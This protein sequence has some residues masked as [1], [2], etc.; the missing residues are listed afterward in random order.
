[1]VDPVVRV[2]TLG[3]IQ[4]HLESNGYEI[5]GNAVFEA[6]MLIGV[7]QHSG[8]NG[9]EFFTFEEPKFRQQINRAIAVARAYDLPVIPSKRE[10]I[11]NNV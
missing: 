1:M 7:L 11:I 10:Y 6:D 5:C 3:D 2:R 9:Y 8:N 4:A